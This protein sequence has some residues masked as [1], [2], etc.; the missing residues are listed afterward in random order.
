M[1]VDLHLDLEWIPHERERGERERE[2]REK[3][4]GQIIRRT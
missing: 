1:D 4:S 3:Q 2:R